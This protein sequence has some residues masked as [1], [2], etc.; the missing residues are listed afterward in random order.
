MP[1][2]SLIERL[3]S[4]QALKYV[5]YGL[6]A[7][8]LL[9]SLLAARGTVKLLAG[10]PVLK[11][12]T[13][14]TD[15]RREEVEEKQQHLL[16]PLQHY[17]PVVEKNV[18]GIEGQSLSTI[19]G[20]KAEA[21]ST[22]QSVEP[23]VKFRLMGTVA[24]SDGTGYAF[25]TE[26]GSEQKLYK[27]GQEIPGAGLLKEIYPDSVVMDFGG[28]LYDVSLESF[29]EGSPADTAAGASMRPRR[30]AE[31]KRPVSGGKD[32]SQ[33]ARRTGDNEFVVSKRAIDESIQN[34][35]NVLTD[36]R[37]LP[38]MD[39]GSQRGFRISEIKRGGLYENLGLLNGDIL[40]GVND[41][42]LS[43]PE[44]ALQAFTTLQGS[45][46]IKLDIERR[47]KKIELKYNIR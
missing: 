15:G 24:W 11:P 2:V 34:P 3:A 10:P 6:A 33:F 14:D 1:L 22:P 39:K 46:S 19:T 28:N 9:A 8:L 17:S 37:L 21:S 35:Q 30:T 7:A 43:S 23:S 25:V 36:A 29:T 42:K 5:N 16:R 45:S 38:N 44:S 41:F 47:G 18:F 12:G 27:A 26:S 31:R 13:V 40:L 4:Q 32:F 20:A